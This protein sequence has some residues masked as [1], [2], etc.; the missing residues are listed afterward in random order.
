MTHYQLDVRV[1]AATSKNLEEEAGK[2]TFRPDLFYRLNVLPIRLPPLRERPEDIP[3]L[4]QHFIEH[5]RQSLN[6]QIQG[7]SS[8]GLSLLMQ[9]D[10]PGNVRE[11]ENIIERA[12]IFAEGT[13]LIPENLPVHPAAKRM[14]GSADREFEGYSLKEAQKIMEK[15]MIVKALAAT[16]GNRTHATQLLEI[17]YPSLLT[18]MKS[19]NILM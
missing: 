12:V 10:W 3:M 7:I 5:F 15:Q 16:G 1:L 8:E 11:L 2:G 6:K 18:K 4:V 17:S 19:Y 14:T 9:Y 13:T